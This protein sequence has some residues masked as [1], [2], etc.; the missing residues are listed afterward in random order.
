MS[1]YVLVT[2]QVGMALVTNKLVC[3]EDASRFDI[4]SSPKVIYNIAFTAIRVRFIG[5]GVLLPGCLLNF[6]ALDI[7]PFWSKILALI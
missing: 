1:G 2:T 7:C 5:Q 6:L 3:S 4:L